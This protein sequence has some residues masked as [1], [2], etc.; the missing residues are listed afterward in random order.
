MEGQA[1]LVRFDSSFKPANA[2]PFPFAPTGFAI[3]PDNQTVGVF[4]NEG[5]ADKVG[6]FVGGIAAQEPPQRIFDKPVS[7]ITWS[8]DSS[9]MAF[10]SA[11]TLLVTPSTGTASPVDLTQGKGRALSPAW[12]PVSPKK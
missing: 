4:A 9:S 12:S 11:G 2:I 3:A 8:P 6:L 1:F 7:A 5:D 10:L